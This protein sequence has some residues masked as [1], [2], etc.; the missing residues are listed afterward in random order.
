MSWFIGVDVGGTFTDFYAVDRDSAQVVVHKT[1]STPH[2]P[3]EAI[4]EGLDALSKAN[5]I[6][7]EAI[8]RLA[9][10]TTV[11]TNALIQRKGAALALI[12]TE[13]F[14]DLLEIGRQIRPKMYDLKADAPPPLVPRKHRYEVRERMMAD[15]T[16]RIALED[17][18][19]EAAID[20]VEGSGAEAVAVCLLFAFL[21][22]EH[23]QKIGK[24]LAERLPNVAVSLSSAVQPEFREYERFST[25]ALNAY[26]QPLIGRYM[27]H[28]GKELEERAP[29]ARLGINQSSGGLMSVERAADFPVRTALSG[30]AAGAVGAAHVARLAGKPNVITLDMGGTSA[31]VALIRDFE[32]EIGF[33]REVAGFPVRL[34]IVDVDTVGAGGGSIA[35]FDRDGLLKVGPASAGAVPGPAC[36]RRGGTEA[37]VSDANL[38]L[39]RLSG[40]LIGGAMTL[41]LDLAR[42]AIQPIADTLGFSIEKTAEGILGI[43][44]AN[45]VRA[46]RTVSVERGHDP[47]HFTLMPFGGAGALHAGDVAR[48]LDMAEIVVP[49]APGILCAQGLVVSDLKED[50]VATARLPLAEASRADIDAAIAPMAEAARAW[51]ETEEIAPSRR[52]LRLAIDLRYV[53]QNFELLVATDETDGSAPSLPDME[54]LKRRFFAAHEKTYGHYTADDPIETVNLRLTAIGE[55]E[56]IP[57]PAVSGD[58][59]KH[60]TPTAHRPVWFDGTEHDTPVYDRATLAPGQQF[61]GPAIVDQLDA[62][63][64]VHPGDTVTVDAALN[65]IIEVSR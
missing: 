53:G 19:I 21:N 30:P 65:L 10:G 26:L 58:G 57:P 61:K 38:V 12:T 5:G 44:T 23:E 18:A 62:T 56:R 35:W 55:A 49:P 46:I 6:P 32:A 22:P 39:G 42:Q 43:V 45:M 51:F 15:G 34:P 7:A 9:H 3:A 40:S 41:D 28:L 29:K 59:S 27:R 31:D 20:Q 11:A 14:R 50:F 16:P 63:T 13:G 1:P 64:V 47:R 54:E 25:A 52:R 36:Y 60:P 4:L 2:N 24:R 17:D 33:G 37:T 8:T 48:A